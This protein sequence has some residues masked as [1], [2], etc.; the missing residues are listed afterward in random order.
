M[1]AFIDVDSELLG[2]N[3]KNTNIGI[4][5]NPFVIGESDYITIEEIYSG[6]TIKIMT[7][8]GRVVKQIELPYNE[9]RINW[10]GKDSRGRYLDSGIYLIVAQNDQYGNGVTKLAIIK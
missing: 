6:S 7:L 9:Y 10:D 3:R 4:S 2:L 5:P 1:V 8:S